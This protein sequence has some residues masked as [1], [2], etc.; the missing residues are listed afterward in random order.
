MPVNF[1]HNLLFK[2]PP[3]GKWIWNFKNHGW[4]WWC[5]WNVRRT[6]SLSSNCIWMYGELYMYVVCL[7]MANLK[8]SKLLSNRVLCLFFEW[9]LIRYWQEENEQKKIN[10]QKRFRIKCYK[11]YWEIASHYT[12][13]LYIDRTLFANKSLTFSQISHQ[14]KC[15]YHNRITTKSHILL[16][17]IPVLYLPIFLLVAAIFIFI[18]SMSISFIGLFI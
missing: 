15:K 6:L 2:V 17:I 8:H 18:A 13:L 4:H 10:N 14:L 1:I 5:E 16:C 7:R 3:N 12:Y 9:K 11:Y